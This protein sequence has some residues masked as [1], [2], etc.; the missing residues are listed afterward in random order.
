VLLALGGVAA[1]T[2]DP[3]AIAD[4]IVELSRDGEPCGS[5]AECLPLVTAGEDVDY[6]GL[7]AFDFNDDGEPDRGA[8]ELWQFEGA[9]ITVL[10]TTVVESE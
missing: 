1:G 6:Q 8:Y 5:F 3:R 10:S 7:T 4:E 9:A 2:D